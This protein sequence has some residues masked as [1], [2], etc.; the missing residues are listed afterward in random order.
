MVKKKISTYDVMRLVDLLLYR[1]VR[2]VVV[3]A[4]PDL[5]SS[6]LKDLFEIDGF[7]T[8][9][10]LTYILPYLLPNLLSLLKFPIGLI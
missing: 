8:Q 9:V 5:L 3:E 2:L 10:S 6:F 1:P 4:G 7:I